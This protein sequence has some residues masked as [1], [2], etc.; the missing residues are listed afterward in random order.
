MHVHVSCACMIPLGGVVYFTNVLYCDYPEAGVIDYY[1]D[2]VV[3]VGIYK[4]A[5]SCTWHCTH[6]EEMSIINV[7]VSII[8]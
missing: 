7:A 5:C 2:E 1:H 4:H 6:L 3:A 8:I